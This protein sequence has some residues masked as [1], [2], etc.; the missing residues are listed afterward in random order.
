MM[1][2]NLTVLEINDNISKCNS[3]A[4]KELFKISVR[5]RTICPDK[6]LVCR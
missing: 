4:F 5:K 1:M 3:R 2:L 6:H